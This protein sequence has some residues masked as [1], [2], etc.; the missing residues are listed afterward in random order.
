MPS[1]EDP[2]LVLQ[3]LAPAHEAAVLAFELVN[4][5]YFAASVSDRG[6]DFFAD[7][8]QRHRELLRLQEAGEAA[9]YVVF[10]DRGDVRGRFNLNAI[11]G[12]VAEVGYRVAQESAGRGLATT[13]LRELARLAA[14]RHGVRTL[15]A[16]VSTAN[17]ASATVLRKAGFVL[18]GPADPSSIG[19]KQGST[20]E[21]RLEHDGAEPKAPGDR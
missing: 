7:Y 20:N 8:P 11:S 16:S 19:G 5:H 14:S 21:L 18:V 9:F 3:P 1:Q 13:G 15:R 17:A 4:R 12:D 10:G 6:D 2:G